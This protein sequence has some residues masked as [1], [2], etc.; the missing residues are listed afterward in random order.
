MQR[1]PCRARPFFR[2]MGATSPIPSPAWGLESGSLWTA[3]LSTKDKRL[4]ARD[5]HARSDPKWS[6]DGRRLVYQWMRMK[7][8]NVFEF[9]LGVRETS[10]ADETLLSTPAEHL[11]QPHE[12][13]P[14]GTSILVSWLRPGA[15]SLLA[16]WPLAA[17]PRADAAA[18]IV[19]ED[20]QGGLW[21][22][23]Y[24]PNGRWISFDNGPFGQSHR[25]RDPERR[26]SG[27]PRPWRCLTD[28]AGLDRQAALVVGREAAV[29]L[30]QGRLAVQRVG[31]AVR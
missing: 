18:S 12:W 25:L 15:R 9:S 1:P 23:R 24:S 3:D 11:V 26:P 5:N 16:L 20:P 4:L 27:R 2:P 22:G 17:A 29:R 6:R 7:G 19:T 30:A 10:A 31:V 8:G 28:P 13:S 21:Q 14:D